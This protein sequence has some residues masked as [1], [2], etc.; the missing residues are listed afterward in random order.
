MPTVKPLE[1][2]VDSVFTPFL[3]TGVAKPLFSGETVLRAARLRSPWERLRANRREAI[4]AVYEGEGGWMGERWERFAGLNA[5][6]RFE[7]CLPSICRS[8]LCFRRP[9]SNAPINLGNHDFYRGNGMS[10][11]S[12]DC[13]CSRD[14][15]LRQQQ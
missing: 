6:M 1:R 7:S 9:I 10:N 14:Y 2:V 4:E 13:Q 11:N 5:V 8:S 12:I 3:M 15:R